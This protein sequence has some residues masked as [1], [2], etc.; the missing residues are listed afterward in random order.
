[1]QETLV[2]EDPTYC[3]ETKPARHT[4][5]AGALEPGSCNYWAYMQ[6]L[7][8][9]ACA[10]QQEK[11]LQWEAQWKKPLLSA[12]REKA[13]QQHR[14]NTDTNTHINETIKEKNVYFRVINLV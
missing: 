6:Q 5:G 4:H 2:Q 10:L 9:R 14:P 13:V 1:M 8:K 12:T 7:L 3:G 11:L